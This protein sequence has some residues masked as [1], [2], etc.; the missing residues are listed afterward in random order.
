[1]SLGR[2]RGCSS[3]L[4]LP[5]TPVMAKLLPVSKRPHDLLKHHQMGLTIEHANLWPAHIQFCFLGGDFVNLKK[6][7]RNVCDS[8]QM[9]RE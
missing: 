1:M 2:N 3:P 6:G 9:G 7:K 8:Y 5:Y 4:A